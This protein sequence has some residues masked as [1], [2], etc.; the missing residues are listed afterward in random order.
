MLIQEDTLVMIC[1][2]TV[3]FIGK[4]QQLL[5]KAGLNLHRATSHEMLVDHPT[6]KNTTIA[7]KGK[8]MRVFSSSGWRHWFVYTPH[9]EQ[10]V[11]RHVAGVSEVTL[12]NRIM[13]ETGLTP[14]SYCLRDNLFC[15]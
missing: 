5:L 9:R 7:F 2:P 14:Q 8:R 1:L 4:R 12:A 6:K 13:K 3:Y 15:Y 11:R 10:V